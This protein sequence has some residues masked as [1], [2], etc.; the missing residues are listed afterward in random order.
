MITATIPKLNIHNAR[1]CKDLGFFMP[2][3]GSFTHGQKKA[4]P[5]ETSRGRCRMISLGRKDRKFPGSDKLPGIGP[6]ILQRA[7][8]A[9]NDLTGP[10]RRK[11][12]FKSKTLLYSTLIGLLCIQSEQP[13]LKINYL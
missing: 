9:S 5:V 12:F 1:I 10:S 2:W 8:I 6:E 3:P 4:R 13:Q 11:E 7:K